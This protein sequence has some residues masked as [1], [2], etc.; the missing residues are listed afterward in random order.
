M[1]KL[2]KLRG[3]L[4]ENK[5]QLNSRLLRFDR[6]EALLTPPSALAELYFQM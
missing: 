5:Q 3:R 1:Y 6:Q 4:W 2:Q